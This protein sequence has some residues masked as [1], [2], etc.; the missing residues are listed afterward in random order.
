MEGDEGLLSEDSHL[1]VWGYEEEKG[2]VE[3]TKWWNE[4]VRCAVR[5]KKVM[6]KRLLDTGTVEAKQNYV[7]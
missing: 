6:Y 3:R 7:Q 2:A 4:E 1:S 5:R